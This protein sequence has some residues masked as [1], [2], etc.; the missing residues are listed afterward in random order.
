MVKSKQSLERERKLELL[1][2]LQFND[3]DRL[4]EFL[5]ESSEG[6]LGG[7]SGDSEQSSIIN[8]TEISGYIQEASSRFANFR[9]LLRVY[10]KGDLDYKLPAA[11]TEKQVK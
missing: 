6:I 10:A 5:R 9:E 2:S 1:K 11:S 8:V 4:E 7:L 3:S